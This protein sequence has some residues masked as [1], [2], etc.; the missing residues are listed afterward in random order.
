LPRFQQLN[1]FV[2]LVTADITMFP[3]VVA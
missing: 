2:T 3:L 1:I